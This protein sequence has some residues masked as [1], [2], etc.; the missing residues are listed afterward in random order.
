MTPWLPEGHTAVLAGRG[1]VFY[2]RFQHADPAAPT[3]LLLHGWTADADSQ[4]FSAY[5]ALAERYSF[6]AIDHRGH[7]RGMRSDER[8]TLEVLADDAA[9]LI[10]LLGVGPV[11]TVGFSM[12]GPVAMLLARRHP[13]L[14]VGQVLQATAL[15]WQSTRLDRWRWWFLMVLGVVL[16]SSLYPRVAR[17]LLARLVGSGNR[18]LGLWLGGELR[19]NDP[20]DVIRLGKALSTYDARPWAAS[21]GVPTATLVTTNDHLIRPAKQ[22]ALAR[23][24]GSSI[25]EIAADHLVTITDPVDYASVTRRQI[26]RIASD[27]P[28]AELAG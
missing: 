12:G 17:R 27:L 22:R 20:A 2:R 23:A 28:A 5:Q 25:D 24:T 16:R 15:E 9:A 21:L 1:E 13:H 3:L 18:E 10:D 8:V 11:I 26:D 7:G 4:F 6:I 19:R 14:V